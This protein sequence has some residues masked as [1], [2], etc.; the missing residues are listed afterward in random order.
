MATLSAIAIIGAGQA[1]GQAAQSLRQAGYEGRLYL[2][3][4][5]PPE[6]GA[7]RRVFLILTLT[8]A[9]T[10]TYVLCLTIALAFALALT[11]RW[12]DITGSTIWA[13]GMLMSLD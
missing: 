2:I 11:K 13:E 9:L 3:G 8:I 5:E 1:G 4:D 12:R 6:R 7:M 10:F